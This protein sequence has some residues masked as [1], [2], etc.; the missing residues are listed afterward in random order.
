VRGHWQSPRSLS[1]DHPNILR[2]AQKLHFSVRP[3]G[4]GLFVGWRH[5]AL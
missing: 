4:A 2:V 3:P 1:T 5:T